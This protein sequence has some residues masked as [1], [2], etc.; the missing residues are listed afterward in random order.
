MAML[1]Y[2]S[3]FSSSLSI[4]YILGE[5]KIVQDSIGFFVSPKRK[6]CLGFFLGGRRGSF[7]RLCVCV[8][9][10]GEV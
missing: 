4:V 8:C 7:P 10:F 6:A 5:S 1:V 9:F 2:R 3:V